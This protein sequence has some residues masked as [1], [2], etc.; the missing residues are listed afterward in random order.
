M[1]P[2]QT[3]KQEGVPGVFAKVGE[4]LYRHRSS[5]VYYGLVK[6]SGKQ[7][8]RSLKTTDRQLA[9]RRLT[10][11][12]EKVGHLNQDKQAHKITFGQLADRWFAITKPRLKESSAARIELCI[13]QLKRSFESTSIRNLTK[14]D[15]DNWAAT[16]EPAV[17]ASTFNKERETLQQILRYASREGLLLDNPADHIERRKLPKSQMVIPTKEQFRTLVE[18]M[19]AL[20]CRATESADLIE[21]LAYSGMRLAEATAMQWQDIDWER[22]TFTVTG[23]EKGT[24]NHEARMVPIFPALRTLLDRM[25]SRKEPAPDVRLISIESARKALSTACRKNKLPL[26][27]HHAMRHYFVS[28]AIEQNIDFKVIA[29]WVGH[30]DGGVLVAKTY[31]HLRDGHAFEMAKRM[32]FTA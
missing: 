15:C 28:N 21:L 19:R 2:D 1:T 4:C 17:S 20:D 12:R 11:F 14:A 27:N 16:R 32:T 31:G 23:G 25:K 9:V 24:K 26:F 8:R 5:G 22:G 29:A 10:D 6:R 30:K 13:K 3:G 18:A 7:F